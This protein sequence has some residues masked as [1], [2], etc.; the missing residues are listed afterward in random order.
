MFPLCL[1]GGRAARCPIS[2][3]L[4]FA[5]APL[6]AHRRPLHKDRVAGGV[7]LKVPGKGWYVY[8]GLGVRLSGSPVVFEA[9]GAAA[10]AGFPTNR[11]DKGRLLFPSRMAEDLCPQ[12]RMT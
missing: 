4:L 3:R 6:A 12:A 9:R 2:D 5:S 10:E 8:K 1:Q 11:K 7:A